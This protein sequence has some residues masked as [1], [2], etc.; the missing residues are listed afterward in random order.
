M[1]DLI[2]RITEVNLRR[3]LSI[4]DVIVF[5]KCFLNC[6]QLVLVVET[7]ASLTGFE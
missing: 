1:T 6:I 3:S 7:Y 2:R 5:E 4:V